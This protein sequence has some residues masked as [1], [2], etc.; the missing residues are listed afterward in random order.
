MYVID[1]IALLISILLNLLIL[2]IGSIWV[3]SK[4]GIPYVMSKI[5]LLQSAVSRSD[6]MNENPHHWDKKT[7]FETLPKSEADIVFFGDSITDYCEW[8]EF[9]RETRIK[10]RGIAGDTT[11]GLL[12][13]IDQV[14]ESQPHKLFILIG[15]NDI[16]QGKKVQEILSNY[17]R[18]LQTCKKRIPQT[19][20]FIQ[21]VLPINNQKLPNKGVNHKIIE[22]NAKLKEFAQ[23]LAFQYID[24]F[25]EFLDSNNQLD[26]RYTT[27]GVH[28][29]GQGYLLWK[30]IIEKDVVN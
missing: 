11:N 6:S 22:V 20:V 21:S 1:K 2:G 10:N 14:I 15:I 18:I 28:L 30:R 29:N 9:F 25:S 5:F 19:Q 23:E 8:Q 27:D 4:G 3:Y 26:E 7:H 24:L 16:N 12:N 13:R 17:Q